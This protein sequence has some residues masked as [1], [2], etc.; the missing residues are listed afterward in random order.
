LVGILRKRLHDGFFMCTV[1]LRK[2][3]H[4]VGNYLG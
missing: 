2:R 1:G 3:L 4:N